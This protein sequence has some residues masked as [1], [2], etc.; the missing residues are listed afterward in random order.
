[1]AHSL[2]DKTLLSLR[3]RDFAAT[4]FLGLCVWCGVTTATTT[5][6]V[7]TAYL[8]ELTARAQAL[9]LASDP[10]WYALLHYRPKRFSAGVESRAKGGDFFRAADGATDPQAE[11][12]A[13]L[14]DFFDPD[15]LVRDGEHPQC[16]FRARYHWLK[17]VLH[18]DP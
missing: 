8:A 18:F 4:V 3:R 6:P 15:V 2:L 13:T 11:L 9:H 17:Q 12:A 1:M 7:D 5:A 16:A 14:K 10:Q